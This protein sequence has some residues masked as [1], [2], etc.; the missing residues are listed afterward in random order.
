MRCHDARLKQLLNADESSAEYQ[1]AAGHVEEG[2]DLEGP[3]GVGAVGDD[4]REDVEAGVRPVAEPEYGRSRVVQ[5]DG[6]TL[7]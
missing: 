2:V 7:V 3:L 6:A 5:V 4:S 1:S